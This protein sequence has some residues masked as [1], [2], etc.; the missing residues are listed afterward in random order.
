LPKRKDD[1]P[2][3]DSQVLSCG[4][5]DLW[6]TE[7]TS[8]SRKRTDFDRNGMTVRAARCTPA[9]CQTYAVSID[10]MLA[11]HADEERPDG[12]RE[13]DVAAAGL[14]GQLL[15]V[16]R[17]QQRGLRYRLAAPDSIGRAPD[18][19][20]YDDMVSSGQTFEMSLLQHN[21]FLASR[22]DAALLL[23]QTMGGTPGVKAIRIGLDGSSAPVRA[24]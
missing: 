3:E 22:H 6:W 20:A 1:H 15:V 21:F 2:V 14:G 10:E 24:E 19:V 5:D 13:K 4:A 11:G 18:V 7:V 17:S 23:L 16:W 12:I 8:E 9:G